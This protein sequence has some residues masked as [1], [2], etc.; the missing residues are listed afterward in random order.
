MQDKTF[1]AVAMTRGIRDAHYEQLKDCS[2]EEILAFYRK[3]AEKATS[4]LAPRLS[5]PVV[6]RLES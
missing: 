4:Q 6:P 3:E 2:R 1:D 5:E